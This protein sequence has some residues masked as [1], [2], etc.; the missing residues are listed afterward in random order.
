MGLLDRLTSHFASD[1]ILEDIEMAFRAKVIIAFAFAVSAWGPIYSLVLYNLADSHVVVGVL[2]AETVLIGGSPF[3]MKLGVPLRALGHWIT[4]NTF[5]VVNSVAWLGFG[6]E[7]VWWQAVVMIVAVLLCGLRT[8]VFWLVAS[9]LNLVLFYRAV[10]AGDLVAVAFDGNTQLLWQASVMS[11]L[12][13]V[14]GLL[15]LA[16]ESLKNWALAGIR[17]RQELTEAILLAAPDAIVTLDN[18]GRIDVVNDAAAEV[19]DRSDRASLVGAGLDTLVPSAAPPVAPGAETDRQANSFVQWNRANPW[20]RHVT[21]AVRGDNTVFPA[22]VSVREIGQDGRFVVVMRDISDLQLA[23]RTLEEARDAALQAN[24]A[25]SSFLAN[26]SH[27]LRT[28]LNAIIGYSELLCED[29]EDSGQDGLV[30]DLQK[31][32]VAGKHLLNLINDILDIS[33]IEAGHMDIYV[34]ELDLHELLDEVASTVR[35]VIEKKGSEFH[36]DTAQAPRMVQADATKLRQILLNLLSNAAKFA[37]QSQVRLGVVMELVD[38]TQYCIFEVEDHGIGIAPEKVDKLFD[39]F[40]QADVSTTRLYGGTGLGLAISKRF[41]EMMGGVI[42]VESA[43]GEGTVFRVHLPIQLEKPI[44]DPTGLAEVSTASE[45]TREEHDGLT[46]LV[47]DDD[48]VVHQLMGEFLGREGFQMYSATSGAMGLEL[49]RDLQPDVITLDVMMS[50]MD[51]WDV[52]SRLKQNPDTEAIPVVMVT[53]V[54]DKKAGFSLGAADYLVKPVDRQKLIKVLNRYSRR[55]LKQPVMLVEDDPITREMMT[56]TIEREGWDLR[57]ASDGVQ[58]IKLLEEGLRPGV[59]LLDIMM[60][61]MDGFE[62]LKRL[63]AHSE[64]A[65]IPVV[66]VSAAVLTA[67]ERERLG[68]Q[69]ELILEKGDYSTAQ[70]LAE[71]QRAVGA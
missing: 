46:V 55:I 42:T 9:M 52:L 20:H 33:K 54:N 71:V 8:G 63:K 41:I 49:A 29:A 64:W 7:S 68:A 13:V 57:S 17:A 28:P 53:I 38:D 70:L 12:Y 56:R 59:I 58:G 44:S 51:G 5:I 67:E 40:E 31:I 60:P 43:L 18:A 6:S 47:I 69:V 62:M 37:A 32:R 10:A 24:Q 61:N 35:P 65:E 16:Y 23:Q 26:M 1:D 4:L 3:W 66:I 11:G 27:E 14:V 30:P 45:R 48:P 15:I 21:E 25:K 50:Q 34:E 39:A 19:F 2:L 36:I 22:D